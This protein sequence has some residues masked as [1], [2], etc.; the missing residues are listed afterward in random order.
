MKEVYW[1]LLKAFLLRF[2]M[3]LTRGFVFACMI[4]AHYSSPHAVFV[5]G[6]CVSLPLLFIALY[7]MVE[8]IR[9]FLN[10]RPN[11]DKIEADILREENKQQIK[12]MS[13]GK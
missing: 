11:I 5:I 3:I 4:F 1:E 12:K 7:R 10:I 9:L 6:A 8:T 13:H 2:Y